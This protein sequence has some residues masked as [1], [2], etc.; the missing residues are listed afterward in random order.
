[1]SKNLIIVESPEK[2]KTLERFLGSDYRVLSSKGHIRDIEGLGKNSMG[3]DLEHGYEPNY[4][5]E[6]S[7][8]RLVQ[9][10]RNEAQKADMVWLATDEDREGEAIAWH[11]K[12]VLELPQ[13]KTK[14]I[15][16]HAITKSDVLEAIANPRDIDYNVVNAQQA[17]RVMDRIVGFE[18]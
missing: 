2:A 17:R 8:A 12:E 15:A 9:T 16:F 11:L 6:E 13:E 10:L 7:K 1:M 5:M 18:L 14:R 3:V 4:V